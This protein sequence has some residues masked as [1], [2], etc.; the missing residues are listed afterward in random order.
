MKHRVLLAL[1]AAFS[2]LAP[3]VA[4]Q[5]DSNVQTSALATVRLLATG[6]ISGLGAPDG[7][8]FL[9]L[10][11]PGTG[12]AGQFTLKETRDFTVAGTSYQEKTQAELG[13][14]FEPRT[15]INKADAFFAQQPGMR[16][17]APDDISSAH[18]L[19]VAIGGTKLPDGAKVEVTAEVGYGKVVEPFR[20]AVTAP[21]AP[22]AAQP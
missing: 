21:P 8:Q 17:L 5:S 10:V 20:F 15:S 22:A 12:V 11:T 19:I 6:R 7:M 14:R 4:A 2:F 16:G 1:L 18:I 3:A 9:F 13:K